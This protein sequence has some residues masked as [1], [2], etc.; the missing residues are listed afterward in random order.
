MKKFLTLVLASFALMSFAQKANNGSAS[1]EPTV[2]K[3]IEDKPGPSF[4]QHRTFP[5]VPDDLWNQLGFKDGIPSSMS[6][7][8]LKTEGKTILLDTGLGAGFSQLIP[9][10]AEDNIKPEDLKLIYITHMH[11]G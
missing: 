4:Q 3:W 7:F 6:C 11:G 2:I 5:T 1:N 9:K 10:L 8:L